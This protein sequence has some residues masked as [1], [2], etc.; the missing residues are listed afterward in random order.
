MRPNLVI[1]VKSIA[2]AS[3]RLSDS[4][5]DSYLTPSPTDGVTGG[6]VLRPLEYGSKPDKVQGC[7]DST[8]R[9]FHYVKILQ[10][11]EEQRTQPIIQPHTQH[12]TPRH[13]VSA[14]LVL[15]IYVCFGLDKQLSNRQRIVR[16]SSVKNRD[17][18]LSHSHTL[19]TQHQDT[20]PV[21]TLVL[22]CTSALAWT[23]SSATANEF[24]SAAS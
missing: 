22:A 6:N 3:P 13:A 2:H 11:C 1:V 8:V 15:G 16:C 4:D 23:S 7:I 9:S 14:H 19:S 17:P 5:P 24:F 10:P 12:A 18:I 21:L 20:Q